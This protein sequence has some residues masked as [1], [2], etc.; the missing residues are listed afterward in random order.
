VA[1]PVSNPAKTSKIT[2]AVQRYQAESAA[3]QLVQQG[4]RN[5][6]VLRSGAYDGLRPGYWVAYIGPFEATAH[7]RRQP[8][9]CNN[10]SQARSSG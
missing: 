1:A 5:A 6:G 4:W 8:S 9:G 7:G 3:Q 10:S 2:S